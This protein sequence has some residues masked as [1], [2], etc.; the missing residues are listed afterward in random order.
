MLE[1]NVSLGTPGPLVPDTLLGVNLELA[2]PVDAALGTD[3]LANPKFA[4]PVDARSG[5][6]PGWRRWGQLMGGAQ[7][8]LI[9]GLFLSPYASQQLTCYSLG[10]RAGMLQTGIRLEGGVSYEVEIW[11]MARHRPVDLVVSL[12]SMT[13]AEPAYDQARLRLDAAYWKRY[14]VTLQARRDDDEAVF[15]VAL[16]S[17][18]VAVFDQ[19]HLRPAGA[20]QSAEAVLAEMR[21]LR[22]P[23][24]RYPG[25]CTSTNYHWRLGVGP[26]HLRPALPDPVFRFRASYQFGIDE[27]LR[28]CVAAGISPFLTVNIGSGTPEEAAELAAYCAAWYADR[29]LTAPV[30]YFQLGNEQFG[31]WELSHM[32]AQMYLAA[33]RAYVPGIRAAYPGARIIALGEE[34]SAG[35]FGEPPSPLRAVLLAAEPGLFDVLALHVYRGAWY[36]DPADQVR[37]V[38]DSVSQVE[39]A[40]RELASAATA[41][42]RQVGIALTEW[43]YWL[44]ATHWDDRD[45]YE[46]DDAVHAIFFAGVLNAIARLAPRVELSTYY[47]LLNAMGMLRARQGA[48]RRTAIADLY[49]LYR[50]ALPG[51]LVQVDMTGRTVADGLALLDAMAVEAADGLVLL[52]A[53]RHPTVPVRLRLPGVAG[54]RAMAA[55]A[56]REPMRPVTLEGDDAAVTM[57]PLSVARILVSPS[58]G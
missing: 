40:I 12:R 26:P 13:G 3:L 44:H 28:Y 19:V 5:L 1:V 4:G 34:T 10:H 48:V 31:M 6:A 29:G 2:D 17:V 57:P 51:R 7:C 56:I 52:V 39:A 32:T 16:D 50:S 11:A 55:P 25:G 8:E 23:L 21:A 42:G 41:A 45:F 54:V 18:G 38:A 27:Y 49:A 22:L 58:R 53:Q 20:G 9:E 15:L 46:P 30:A 14:T 47:H 43:H 37:H 24:I 33:L 36:D 35:A